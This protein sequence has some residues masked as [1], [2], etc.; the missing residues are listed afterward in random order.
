MFPRAR[1]SHSTLGEGPGCGMGAVVGRCGGRTSLSRAV[2]AWAR[3]ATQPAVGQGKDLGT[4]GLPQA[5]VSSEIPS[6]VSF[7]LQPSPPGT[8]LMGTGLFAG[9]PLSFLTS[10]GLWVSY[11]KKKVAVRLD[12]PREEV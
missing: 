11:S 9:G 3:S 1:S 8:L 12:F 6:C 4:P 7:L 10:G 5:D 2:L